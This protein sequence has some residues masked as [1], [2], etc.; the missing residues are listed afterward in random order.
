[1]RIARIRDAPSVSIPCASRLHHGAVCFG[2]P[3]VALHAA[4][5]PSFE[6]LREAPCASFDAFVRHP[7]FSCFASAIELGSLASAL[8]YAPPCV[9]YRAC[10]TQRLMCAVKF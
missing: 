10:V 5:A 7:R 3:C 2:N 6:I 1:M 4:E 8:A 9:F